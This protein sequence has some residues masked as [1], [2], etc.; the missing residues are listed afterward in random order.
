VIANHRFVLL[1]GDGYFTKTG[2]DKWSL[3]VKRV[4]KKAQHY[5]DFIIY[6]HNHVQSC[7]N[8]TWPILINPGSLNFPRDSKFCHQWAVLEINEQ[9]YCL[10]LWGLKKRW[11][12]GTAFTDD[13]EDVVVC[14]QII[15]AFKRG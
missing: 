12:P 5:P 7:E 8:K 6:G 1:H 2:R 13:Y 3:E 15:G 14:E 11:H 10:E 4:L 9:T